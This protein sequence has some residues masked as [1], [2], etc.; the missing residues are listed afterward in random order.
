MSHPTISYQFPLRSIR[1]LSELVKGSSYLCGR[2]N[3]PGDHIDWSSCE[4][5]GERL[6]AFGL[7]IVGHPVTY[8]DEF[9]CSPDG[10]A[11]GFLIFELPND[12]IPM[13][14]NM[15]A[16][17]NVNALKVLVSD[18]LEKHG[19]GTL[20][21]IDQYLSERGYRTVDADMF[22]EWLENTFPGRFLCLK[23]IT[24]QPQR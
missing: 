22:A 13:E 23:Q 10:W 4:F 16:I 24:D 11:S 15:Q 6:I 1:Q 14:I 19:T 20:E 3:L 21:Q 12:L 2:M 18:F 7:G 5:D 9:A 8:Q 17:T